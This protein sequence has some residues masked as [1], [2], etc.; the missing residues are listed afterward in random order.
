MRLRCERGDET[1]SAA[2]AVRTAADVDAGDALPEGGDGLGSEDGLALGGGRMER[3]AGARY[4]MRLNQSSDSRPE[5][6]AKS[7]AMPESS[8]VTSVSFFSRLRREF[9]VA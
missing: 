7:A 6:M 3:G 2:L 1:Q 4:R 9:S 5:T 8:A